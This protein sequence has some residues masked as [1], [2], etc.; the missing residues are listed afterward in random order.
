[1]KYIGGS[2]LG[3]VSKY[4]S[5]NIVSKRHKSI[6]VFG[7]MNFFFFVSAGVLIYMHSQ[8]I[9]ILEQFPKGMLIIDQLKDLVA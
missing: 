7:V 8:G 2:V 1:M 4:D 3:A 9:S 6:M 5:P